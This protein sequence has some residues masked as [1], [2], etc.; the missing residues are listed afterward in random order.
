MQDMYRKIL[1]SLTS[2]Q[3]EVWELEDIGGGDSPADGSEVVAGD[4]DS[5]ELA[6][7]DPNAPRKVLGVTKFWQ[8]QNIKFVM[9]EF[10]KGW[11]R[12]IQAMTRH[13]WDLLSQA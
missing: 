4:S 12:L 8:K 11:G 2:D 1:N 13:A 10:L 5:K 6:I 3:Q 7:R 9:E